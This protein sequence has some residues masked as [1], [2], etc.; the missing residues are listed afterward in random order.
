MKPFT[1]S[2]ALIASGIWFHSFAARIVKKFLR[3]SKFAFWGMM[4]SCFLTSRSRLVPVGKHDGAFDQGRAKDVE[5]FDGAL[6]PS[7]LLDLV[8]AG[9]SLGNLFRFLHYARLRLEEKRR[10][11][12]KSSAGHVNLR[13][14]DNQDCFLNHEPLVQPTK[15]PTKLLTMLSFTLGR[16]CVPSFINLWSRIKKL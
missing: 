15:P 3:I 7:M 14:P 10:W 13:W 8:I 5:H 12:G 2:N 9:Q 6:I 11:G 16:T 1:V 4:T